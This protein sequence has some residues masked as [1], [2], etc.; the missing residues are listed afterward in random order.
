M[1]NSFKLEKVL[2]CLS[3]KTK[4]DFSPNATLNYTYAVCFF[5]TSNFIIQHKN[6]RLTVVALV[7]FS[8]P[9]AIPKNGS[10]SNVMYMLFVFKGY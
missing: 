5:L 10:L 3:L 7:V 9:I 8:L 1:A 2:K 4:G 6:N